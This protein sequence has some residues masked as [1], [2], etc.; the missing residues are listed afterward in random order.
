MSVL[1]V[2]SKYHMYTS[3]NDDQD[4][5]DGWKKLS[6]QESFREAIDLRGLGS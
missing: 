5:D 2:C 6:N 3:H 1:D 4:D